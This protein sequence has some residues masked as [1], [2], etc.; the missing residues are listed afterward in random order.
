MGSLNAVRKVLPTGKNV[1]C[2]GIQQ[3]HPIQA[4]MAMHGR[5]L[6]RHAATARIAMGAYQSS[7]ATTARQQP[8]AA[9][10]LHLQQDG[11]P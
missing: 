3:H 8:M 1:G 4:G 10:P 9:E 2:H 7:A 6:L 5:Q 11:T